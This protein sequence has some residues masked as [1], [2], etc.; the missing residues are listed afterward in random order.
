MGVRVRVRVGVGVGVSARAR[1]RVSCQLPPE[2]GD[3]VRGQVLAR[4]GLA[5]RGDRR[6]LRRVGV[7]PSHALGHVAQRA[8][9]GDVVHPGAEQRVPPLVERRVRK[10]D[11]RALG[12]GVGL[13]V[14]LVG[15][16]LVG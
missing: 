11:G 1:V 9:H 15:L 8:L 12:V 2:A 16:G 7:G 13:G 10:E 4:E 14:G 5:A 6:H 3:G